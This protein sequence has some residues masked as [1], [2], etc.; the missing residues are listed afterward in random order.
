MA[1]GETILTLN[2]N[3]CGDLTRRTLHDGGDVVSFWLRANER[4]FDKS[5]GTWVDGKHFA[6][7]VTCW[8]RLAGQ[9]YESLGKGDP[10]IVVGK[11]H[12]TEYESEGQRRFGTELEAFAVGPNLAFCTA[13]VRR[14]GPAAG[15]HGAEHRAA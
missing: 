13:Q 6:T 9:V 1:I 15:Q 2:G 10:V 4:R 3:V 14:T 5:T 12:T 7:R 11:L 8:R